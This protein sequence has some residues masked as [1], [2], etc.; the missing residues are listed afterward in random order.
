[1][2]IYH[3]CLPCIPDYLVVKSR[4]QFQWCLV[5]PAGM[6][7]LLLSTAACTRTL[8]WLSGS[9]VTKTHSACST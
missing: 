2:Q 9:M 5:M 6:L 3:E 4:V 7:P 1:M 8:L